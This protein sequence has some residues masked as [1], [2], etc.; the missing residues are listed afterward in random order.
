MNYPH[1][2]SPSKQK[3]IVE[4]E[5]RNKELCAFA[6]VCVQ[7]KDLTNQVIKLESDNELQQ[8][9]V[10]DLLGNVND[11]N[12]H[13]NES[14]ST[15]VVDLNSGC[16]KDNQGATHKTIPTPL[17]NESNA[18]V[19]AQSKSG[20]DKSNVCPASPPRSKTQH[21][22]KSTPAKRPRTSRRKLK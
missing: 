6:F 12:P 15:V 21:K 3:R 8:H 9:I 19:V 11:V 18:T 16:D 17:S 5:K 10:S 20:R 4:L 1:K 7:N 13:P 22:R 14:S 2:T